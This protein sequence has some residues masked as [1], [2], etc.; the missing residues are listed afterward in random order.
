MHVVKEKLGQQVLGT[1]GLLDA[2]VLNVMQQAVGLWVALRVAGT[3][4]GK[5]RLLPF[6]KGRQVAGVFEVGALRAGR[7]AV[8]AQGQHIPDADR[9]QLIQ[10]LRCTGLVV[11]HADQVRQR[12]DMQLVLNVVGHL[13]GG[14]AARRAAC[15]EGD[16]DEAGVHGL[17]LAQ[18]VLELIHLGGLFRREAFDRE[19]AAFGFELFRNR[20][21]LLLIFT[22]QNRRSPRKFPR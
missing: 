18:S 9:F 19:N 22:P 10:N 16:A 3:V 4:N 15:T 6:D 14:D 8:P 17:H 20:H 12:G 1:G 5:F 13:R 21:F 2:Q 11:A 7:A